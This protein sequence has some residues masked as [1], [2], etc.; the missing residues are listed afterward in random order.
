MICKNCGTSFEGNFCSHCGQ[1]ADIHRITLGHFF[2]ELFHVLTHTDKGILLLAKDLITRPGHVARE[3][4][5]GKR[6]KYFH[7]LSFLVITAAVFAYV[8]YQTG[9]LKLISTSRGPSTENTSGIANPVTSPDSLSFREAMGEAFQISIDNEKVLSLV[10]I[11]PLMS[12]FTWLLF[13]RSKTNFAENLV[14]SSFIIAESNIVFTLVFIPA[15]LLAPQAA[16]L[17]NN[18][19]HVVFLIY[20]VVAYRQFF[21]N[22]IFLTILKSVLIMV[23]YIAFFWLVIVAYVFI[24]HLIV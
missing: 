6:K 23:G 8:S 4:L 20:M 16:Q 18:I 7:P 21:K 17:N 5:D 15:F 12:F 22:N 2:H 14:L 10:L 1:K 11:F 13:K 3:Y 9:Y 24:K 19:Y